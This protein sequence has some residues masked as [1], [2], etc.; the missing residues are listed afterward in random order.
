MSTTAVNVN[1]SAMNMFICNVG[2]HQGQILINSSPVAALLSDS[3]RCIHIIL[4]F[5]FQAALFIMFFGFSYV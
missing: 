2:Q 4:I 3:N 5:L 1:D